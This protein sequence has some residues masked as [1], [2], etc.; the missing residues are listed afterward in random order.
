MVIVLFAYRVSVVVVRVVEWMELAE[1]I[2]CILEA[3]ALFLKFYKLVKVTTLD[4]PLW[5][6]DGPQ[7]PKATKRL[8]CTRFTLTVMGL[9]I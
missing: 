3:L 1:L 8:A 6:T 5:T 7:V 4:V 9:R 2:L